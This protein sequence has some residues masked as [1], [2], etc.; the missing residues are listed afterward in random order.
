MTVS[1]VE[2]ELLTLPQHL[3]SP[4]V[5]SG[6]RE[7]SIFS[8]MHMFCRTL[9]VLLYFSFW[10]LCCLLFFDIYTDS[11]HPYL[12]TL[13]TVLLKQK[14]RTVLDI[15]DFFFRMSTFTWIIMRNNKSVIYS[16]FFYFNSNVFNLYTNDVIIKKKSSENNFVGDRVYLIFLLRHR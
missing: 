11:D 12:Q 15:T 8:F 6:V 10:P 1:L 2:Q 13:H 14:K 7:L 3:S 5:Y 16:N 9:H 4:P